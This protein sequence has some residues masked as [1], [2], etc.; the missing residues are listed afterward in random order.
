[1]KVPWPLNTFYYYNTEVRFKWCSGSHLKVTAKLTY[2]WLLNL[3]NI[4]I[5][6]IYTPIEIQQEFKIQVLLQIYG[7]TRVYCYSCVADTLCI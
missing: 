5:I 6:T 3:E 4:P 1:M 7:V 2:T